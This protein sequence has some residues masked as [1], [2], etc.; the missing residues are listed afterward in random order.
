MITSLVVHNFK[1]FRKAKFELRPLTVFTGLNGT[2]KST[3]I[4]ALLL[5]K[6][7]AEN[8]NSKVVRLNGVYGL[9]LGTAQDV[10]HVNAP[11]NEI[12]ISLT[13]TGDD[14]WEYRFRVLD[15]DPEYNLEIASVPDAAPSE[16]HARGLEFTL[17]TAERLGPRDQL[18]VSADERRR[19][20]VG[21]RGEYT[22]QVM[23]MAA[24]E[25]VQASMLHPD[26]DPE[27][28]VTILRAQVEAW[29]S[30]I[31]RPIRIEAQYSTSVMAATIRFRE[32]DLFSEPI[33]PTNMGF[34][35]SYALP[36]IVA[37]LVM[38]PG[39]LLIVE[40]PEAHLHPAGQS[41]LGSFLARVAGSGI[42]VLVETHSDHVVN[43]IRLAAA[44][45]RAIPVGDVIL[46]FFGDTIAPGD[47]DFPGSIPIEL[48]EKGGLSS[49]P[50]GFFDQLETDLGRLARAKR[51]R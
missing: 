42:Q 22:A 21:S 29:A 27:Q 8:S 46:H 10:L 49:W 25:Q 1:R 40:N 32:E 36:I 30:S 3:A 9:E 45:E 15:G 44:E 37:G 20:G 16:L 11:R 35:F 6:Q 47:A 33:R 17:L 43:G 38:K 7:A 5:A 12:G 13:T 34:G 39:S 24:N 19:V 2:G 4:Q 28:P 51:R 14:R 31:I 18:G 23:A 48:T 26:T 41:R 50:D